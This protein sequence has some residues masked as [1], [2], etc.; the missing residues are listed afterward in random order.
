MSDSYFTEYKL[1]T[2]TRFNALTTL[3]NAHFENVE[4]KL[5]AIEKQTSKTNG[6]VDELEDSMTDLEKDLSEAKTWAHHIVDTRS[7]NCPNIKEFR[8]TSRELIRLEKKI[9]GVKDMK[10]G[11]I[12]EIKDNLAEYNII[13]KYPKLIVIVLGFSLLL[14]LST[15]LAAINTSRN[16]FKTKQLIETVENVQMDQKDVPK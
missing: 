6:R 4:G 7:E 9:D 3:M 5:S 10:A 12:E 11:D 15:I 16:F 14:F 2:D 8:R 13:K 1:H